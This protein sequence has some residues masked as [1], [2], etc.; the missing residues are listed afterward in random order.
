M[1]TFKKLGQY[2]R[3]ANQMFQAATTIALALRNNDDYILPFCD[4]TGTTNIPIDKF[5]NDIKF[6]STYNEPHYHYSPIPYKPNLNLHGYV[7]SYKYFEDYS[8]EIKKLLMPNVKVNKMIG[9]TSIHVRRT[10]YLIHKNCYHNLT[11]Q[12]YYDKAMELSG[13]KDFLIFSDDIEWCKREFTGNEF[14][15]VEGNPD[16]L[17]MALMANCDQHIIANS[18]FSWWAGYLSITNGSVF[19]PDKWFGPEL[20]KTHDTKDLFPENWIKAI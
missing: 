8:D 14:E 1:I 12:N 18:S 6:T 9:Y 16:Y 10:D 3:R 15:F 2:G 5:S 4:L 11:R 7:Q 13:R 17:D 19:Y 20:E